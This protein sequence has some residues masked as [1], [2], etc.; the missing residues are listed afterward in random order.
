MT[1]R[2]VRIM[3]Y[4]YEDQQAFEEDMDRWLC[5]PI[6]TRQFGKTRIS[7]AI[8]MPHLVKETRTIEED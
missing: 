6:G 2:I 7:S 3:E 8:L 1:I 5:A 4:E